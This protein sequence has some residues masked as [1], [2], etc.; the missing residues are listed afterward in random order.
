MAA[1][2]H[3]ATPAP[4]P[5]GVAEGHRFV[6]VCGL[7]RSGTSLLASW[8]K[9]HPA[10]SGFSGTGVPEDEGQHLQSVY[11]P[12]SASG[13]P[14][15]FG[16]DP[17]AHLTEDSPLATP[18]NRQ[19]LLDAWVPHWDL[20]RPVLVEKSPPNLVRTRFL[21]ALFPGA[22]F[23]VLMRDP[24]AVSCATRKWSGTSPASLLEHWLA[25]HETYAADAPHLAHALLLRYEDLVA[26]PA[27]ELGRVWDFLGLE[28]VA[29][30]ADARGGINE[31]YH[32]EW[33]TWF[34]GPFGRWRW[35]R[36]R[37]RLEGRVGRFGYALPEW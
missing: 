30:P 12:A 27:G 22:A 9:G 14:G 24:V 19:R 2:D 23:V 32:A 1:L 36:L 29:A 26:D 7:H 18:A 31:R 25:C 8:L 28:P 16:F 35:R 37:E 13:G 11:P 3:P 6:F 15:R 5:G 34:R 4:A 20:S 17:A 10:V 21:Q 33:R